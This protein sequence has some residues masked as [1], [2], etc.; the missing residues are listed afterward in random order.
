[1]KKQIYYQ[2][3]T[4]RVSAFFKKNIY[5][6]T[7]FQKNCWFED[8]N[9]AEKYKGFLFE[10]YFFSCISCSLEQQIIIKEYEIDKI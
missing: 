5:C 2:E 8:I 7:L 3:S 9:E 6:V 1:M 10:L 4:A